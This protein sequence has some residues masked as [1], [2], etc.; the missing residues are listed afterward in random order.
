VRGSGLF[1]G[2]SGVVANHHF[3]PPIDGHSFRFT[4][5]KYRIDVFARILGDSKQTC[6]FSQ[7]LDISHGQAEELKDPVAGL[8]F[9]WG[10]DSSRYIS[11]VRRDSPPEADDHRG[12]D[13]GRLTRERIKTVTDAKPHAVVNPLAMDDDE[14]MKKFNG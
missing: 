2:E 11:H 14:F 9:D 8:F 13:T 5:G 12:A 4:E 6:L 1:V 3:M 7:N 10:P